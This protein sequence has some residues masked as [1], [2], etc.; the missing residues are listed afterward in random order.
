MFKGYIKMAITSIRRS[1]WR[2]LLTMFGVI[3]GIV[4]VVTTVSLGEGIKHQVTGEIKSYGSDV[5]TIRPGRLVNRD[6]HG[7]VKSVNI[8]NS[9][10]ANTITNADLKTIA[11]TH[12]V[13]QSVPLAIV[14]G[15]AT[16]ESVSDDN[17]IIMA[18]TPDA[19]QLINQK[20]EFGSFF[21]DTDRAA[22][23]V[24]IGP[25]I[26]QDLFQENVPIGRTLKVRGQEFVVWGV[27]QA[28]SSSPIT[29][30]TDFNKSIVMPYNVAKSLSDSPPQISQ[31]LV[32]AENTSQINQTI[33]NI[34]IELK[35]A[36]GD[37]EDFTILKPDETLAATSSVVTL[38][39]SFVSGIAGISLFV[40]GI[41]IM[42]IML[43][44]VSERT[45][46]IGIRKAVGA[47]NH[48]IL[49]QFLTEAM[50]LSI[51]G[52]VLGIIIAVIC[53]YLLRIFTS[54]TPIVT[55]PVILVATGVSLLVGIIFGVIPAFQASRKDPID[56]LRY[57]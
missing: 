10:T 14:S 18:T 22:H 43:V 45:R 44:S 50:V 7:K 37:Q 33:Q 11:G 12:G 36:H 23:A 42:N 4:S 32:R 38:L 29:A 15:K 5:I 40:G 49:S 17:A 8:I 46:E 3:V 19:L 34:T 54:L 27:F 25:K 51:T 47:T 2:S 31:V 56:A 20:I 35:R 48:Q 6:Q 57:E 55:L 24:I 53:S 30:A 26:A 41:G 21:T 1:K 9:F 13:K 16:S 39:T 52:G 28:S